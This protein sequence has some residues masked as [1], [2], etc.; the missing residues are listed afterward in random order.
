[1]AFAPFDD[2]TPPTSSSPASIAP[3]ASSKCP[4]H[5]WL[6]S[7]LRG[8]RPSVLLKRG[9][10]GFAALFTLAGLKCVLLYVVAPAAVAT[11]ALAPASSESID[12]QQMP[13][14]CPVTGHD[15]SAVFAPADQPTPAPAA[16]AGTQRENPPAAR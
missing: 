16:D 15:A 9:G 10:V 5:A 11:F 13:L 2:P 8:V 4:V 1:M 3:A 7:R 12:V 6:P 14:R